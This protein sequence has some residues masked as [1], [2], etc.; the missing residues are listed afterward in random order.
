M[1]GH[2]GARTIAIGVRRGTRKQLGEQ[3]RWLLVHF[4]A[5][6]GLC[7]VL[8]PLPALAQSSSTPV[9]ETGRISEV[10]KVLRN[11]PL[12]STRYSR[13]HDFDVYFLVRV[14]EQT[15]C[16]DYETVVLDE[17]G[18]LKSSDGKDVELTLNA[19]KKRLVLYTPQNRK[20]KARIVRAGDCSV[21]PLDQRAM[22]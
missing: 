22:R 2:Q 4:V 13:I 18:E 16:G 7:T 1:N 5:L 11:A 8:V 14:H 12:C 10:R 6:A 15:Y 20:L 3:L 21:A 17:I 19:Y 9:R